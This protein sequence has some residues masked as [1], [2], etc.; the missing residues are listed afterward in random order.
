MA[1]RIKRDLNLFLSPIFWKR[2][3]SQSWAAFFIATAYKTRPKAPAFCSVPFSTKI[4]I[5]H[6]KSSNL[7]Q[8]F[9]HFCTAYGISFEFQHNNVLYFLLYVC[10][11]IQKG[12]RQELMH[13]KEYLIYFLWVKFIFMFLFRIKFKIHA[14][15]SFFLK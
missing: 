8:Q 14:Y 4:S 3:F 10:K 12:T 5:I 7:L 6:I 15:V 13:I 11:V 2:G 1:S 9:S